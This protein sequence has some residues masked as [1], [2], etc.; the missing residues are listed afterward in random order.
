M[1]LAHECCDPVPF[2]MV[3]THSSVDNFFTCHRELTM[4]VPVL[5]QRTGTSEE[6]HMM[7]LTC[8]NVKQELLPIE[9]LSSADTCNS[10][11]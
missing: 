5:K 4:V 10:N 1:A 7:A 6:V 8:T 2:H 11:D 3:R 9:V